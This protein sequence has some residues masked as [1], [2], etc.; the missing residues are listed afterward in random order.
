MSWSYV[1]GSIGVALG[2][3]NLWRNRPKLKITD[4]E[5]VHYV[6]DNIVTRLD[7]YL[8]IHNR[9]DKSTTVYKME[10]M[11]GPFTIHYPLFASHK[12]TI[13]GNSSERFALTYQMLGGFHLKD[14]SEP[15]PVQLLIRHTYGELKCDLKISYVD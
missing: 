15:I 9:G 11:V 14:R 3:Y 7:I 12:K 6:K 8:T 13:R 2:L 10:I 4:A 1:L 5:A